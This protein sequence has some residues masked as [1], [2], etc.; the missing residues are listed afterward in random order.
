MSNIFFSFSG[1]AFSDRTPTAL[2]YAEQSVAKIWT[3]IPIVLTTYTAVNCT[4]NL[5]LN[6][7]PHVFISF[8]RC[9]MHELRLTSRTSKKKSSRSNVSSFSGFGSLRG[10]RWRTEN[11][12][13][14]ALW[15]WTCRVDNLIA[16]VPVSSLK[17]A[18]FFTYSYF[19][20]VA[21]LEIFSVKGSTPLFPEEKVGIRKSPQ[22]AISV[23]LLTIYYHLSA[24][25]FFISAI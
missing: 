17:T 19:G 9:K 5:Y 16:R 14:I 8:S 18:V 6:V 4:F 25:C 20:D 15:I 24:V 21:N 12:S 1:W 2:L 7:F 13:R 10:W 23:L 22:N 3:V 11:I